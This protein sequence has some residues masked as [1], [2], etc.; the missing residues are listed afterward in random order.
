MSQPKCG[1][2]HHKLTG[3]K[4]GKCPKCKTQMVCTPFRCPVCPKCNK[5]D[6]EPCFMCRKPRIYCTH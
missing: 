1:Y 4:I 5:Q 6:F 2:T 3:K